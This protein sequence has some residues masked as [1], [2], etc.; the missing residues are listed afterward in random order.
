MIMFLQQNEW[1]AGMI[2]GLPPTMLWISINLWHSNGNPISGLRTLLTYVR[3]IKRIYTAAALFGVFLFLCFA[4]LLSPTTLLLE[5]LLR[6][7]VQTP[8]SSTQQ[9]L[10]WFLSLG[11]YL[12]ANL[13][14]TFYLF[15]S[16]L[17]SYGLR[18]IYEA[19]GMKARADGIRK[20]KRVYGLETE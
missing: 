19:T 11:F 7:N 2:V 10:H 1:P 9:W 15:M 4:L 17:L 5:S 13:L 20:Q 18:E 12:V 14:L 3:S 6:M 8:G 16:S